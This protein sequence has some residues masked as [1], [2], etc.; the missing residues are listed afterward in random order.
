MQTFSSRDW[1]EY[2]FWIIQKRAIGAFS[3]VVKILSKIQD[4]SESDH[5]PTSVAQ[6]YYMTDEDLTT[7]LH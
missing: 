3:N 4:A 1:V 6:C 5:G 2:L 7:K